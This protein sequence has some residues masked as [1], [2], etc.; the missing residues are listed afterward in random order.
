MVVRI[1]A[2]DGNIG[3]GKSTFIE[4]LEKKYLENGYNE[5]EIIFLREPVETWN[6]FVDE[7]GNSILSKFYENQQKYSFSFQLMAYISR[8]SQLRNVINNN[9][10]C[11]IICERSVLTDRFVF[12]K[13][14]YDMGKIEKICYDIYL[15]WFDEFRQHITG[16]IYIRAEPKISLERIKKR[17]RVGEDPISLSYIE[18]CHKYHEEWL[19]CK[20]NVLIL[21]GNVDK[22]VDNDIF[23]KWID[24]VEKFI[25]KSPKSLIQTL[26]NEIFDTSYPIFM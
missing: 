17:N 16:F 3:S 23:N 7:S 10:N 13:M 14:L 18:K 26:L 22:D 21:D 1:Y 12:A 8:I 15:K 9:P 24:R 6:T 2:V 4:K 5:E 20:N 25:G 11:I 19:L